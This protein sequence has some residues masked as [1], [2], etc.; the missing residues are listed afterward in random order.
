MLI[1]LS[2]CG[3]VGNAFPLIVSEVG[4][5]FSANNGAL[6]RGRDPFNGVYV[7]QVPVEG[8]VAKVLRSMGAIKREKKCVQRI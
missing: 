8:E 2:G 3:Y 4:H 1:R 6:H 5:I 7:V